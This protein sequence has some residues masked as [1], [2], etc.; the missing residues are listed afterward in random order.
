MFEV[1]DSPRSGPVA[2]GEAASS[3]HPMAFVASC[4]HPGMWPAGIGGCIAVGFAHV[5]SH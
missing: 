4:G 2:I 5:L 3:A 1:A